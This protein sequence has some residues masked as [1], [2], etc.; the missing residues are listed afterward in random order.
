MLLALLF[1]YMVEGQDIDTDISTEVGVCVEVERI[2]FTFCTRPL[3]LLALLALR[4]PATWAA[5]R[6]DTP[7][8]LFLTLYRQCFQ[9]YTDTVSYKKRSGTPFVGHAVVVRYY[10]SCRLPCMAF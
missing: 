5:W 4:N 1:E 7:R 2:A 9:H 3:A 8:F 6:V 10:A